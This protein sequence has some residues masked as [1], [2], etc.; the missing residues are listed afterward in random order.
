MAGQD[1]YEIL[2]QSFTQMRKDAIQEDFVLSDD[3]IHFVP[4]FRSPFKLPATIITIMPKGR[5]EGMY[6]LKPIEVEGPCMVFMFP[7]QIVEH[8]TIRDDTE[9]KLIIMSNRFAETMKMSQS[10]SAFFRFQQNPVLKLTGEEL[11]MVT[12]FYQL[13]QDV[14]RMDHNGERSEVIKYLFLALFYAIT[15]FRDF[16]LQELGKKSRGEEVF[17]KFYRELVQ[18]HRE[19]REVQYYADKLCMAPKYMARIIKEVSGKSATQWINEYVILEAKTLLKTRPDMT[20]EDVS[21]ELGFPNQ[22]F[23]GKFF[24]QHTGFTPKEF[25]CRA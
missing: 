1:L 3:D 7:D 6:D 22:S 15:N 4:F 10:Y 17:E 11:Q 14:V 18:H 23:F 8:H 9:T 12:H 25:R 21:D 24:K 19:S 5:I 2:R 13:L 16:N 20:L